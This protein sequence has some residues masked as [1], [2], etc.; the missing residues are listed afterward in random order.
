LAKT[1]GGKF[2]KKRNKEQNTNAKHWTKSLVFPSEK[3]ISGNEQCQ[4]VLPQALETLLMFET[5]TTIDKG[6][7][8]SWFLI[9]SVYPI[10]ALVLL[11][12]TSSLALIGVLFRAPLRERL[13]SPVLMSG[14]I[15]GVSLMMLLGKIGQ[16]CSLK[17]QR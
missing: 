6:L 8:W 7:P 2:E 13:V 1:V 16:V 3:A 15:F 17:P 9:L 12:L 14:V 11:P 10:G 4:T 5:N